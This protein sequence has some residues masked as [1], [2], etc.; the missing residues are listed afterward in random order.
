MTLAFAHPVCSGVCPVGPGSTCG[1]V[2]DSVTDLV[3]DLARALMAAKEGV[4]HLAQRLRDPQGLSTPERTHLEQTLLDRAVTLDAAVQGM[5]NAS[6]QLKEAPLHRDAAAVIA[7][8]FIG[9][10]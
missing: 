10:V 1:E 2:E 4:G 5:W 6:R 8:I 9:L 3:Q 7:R